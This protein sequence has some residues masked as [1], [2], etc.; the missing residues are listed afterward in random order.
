VS[1]ADYETVLSKFPA[2][3]RI[4]SSSEFMYNPAPLP[5]AASLQDWWNKLKRI[6]PN[7]FLL[8]TS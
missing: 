8:R 5:D 1:D 4:I 6:V 2:A 3:F 7:S